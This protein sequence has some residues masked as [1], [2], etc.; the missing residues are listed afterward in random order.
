MREEEEERYFSVF[1]GKS[2]WE[3]EVGKR[4][5]IALQKKRDLISRFC[6]PFYP[7]R[8]QFFYAD[9]FGTRLS[10]LS[11]EMD[12]ICAERQNHF[13]KLSLFGCAELYDKLEND[14]VFMSSCQ[15]SLNK[16]H[17]KDSWILSH[18]LIFMIDDDCKS[19]PPSLPY[20]NWPFVRAT[21][22][23]GSHYY[24]DITEQ[25]FLPM[26][27][28]YGLQLPASFSF[29]FW[30]DGALSCGLYLTLPDEKYPIILGDAAYQTCAVR[31]GSY[32][33]RIGG[34]KS[35][36]SAARIAS[37]Q[38]EE[39]VFQNPRL[40]ENPPSLAEDDQHATLSALND[41]IF[42]YRQY[43]R[44]K[45]VNTRIFDQGQLKDYDPLGY[46]PPPSRRLCNTLS[47][48]QKVHE[49]LAQHPAENTTDREILVVWCM[50]E[51]QTTEWLA[52]DMGLDSIAHLPEEV[53]QIPF[54]ICKTGS[55]TGDGRDI[56]EELFTNE[57]EHM[58]SKI[59]NGWDLMSLRKRLQE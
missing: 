6:Q 56:W 18:P 30:S 17:D 41:L 25:D 5:K 43:Q 9:M 34:K 27:E 28:K 1:V 39:L 13:F 10:E 42:S 33:I 49:Y 22:T 23:R 55:E 51:M 32:G 40:D 53:L 35:Q 15:F 45:P 59:G 50:I 46:R 48:I 57:T 38:L 8:T 20:Y 24:F 47:L 31:C 12:S 11:N 7:E 37:H 52:E 3:T 21:T 16:S 29:P 26:L 44:C 2:G 36:S 4:L 58:L 54:L 19:T 14:V